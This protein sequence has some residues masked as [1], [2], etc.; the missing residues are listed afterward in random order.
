MVATKYLLNTDEIRQIQMLMALLLC[1]PP[2]SKLRE[3]FDRALA[4]SESQT[5]NRIKPC[6][7]AS[8][9]GLRDWF[10]SLM[11]QGGLT[12][13]EQ[14]LLDWQSNSDNMSAAIK[15]FTSIQDK[16]NLKISF[17]QKS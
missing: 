9:A 12:P 8:I 2:Q 16:T 14:S 3:V 10:E 1:I 7:D 15:E 13:E 11:I 5:L 17:Q 6:T 4:A